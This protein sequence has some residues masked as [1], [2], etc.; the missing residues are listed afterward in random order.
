[1]AVNTND[2]IRLTACLGWPKPFHESK[3]VLCEISEYFCQRK[4]TFAILK[5]IAPV[6]LF[7]CM[8]SQLQRQQKFKFLRTSL[9]SS[10]LLFTVLQV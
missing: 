3:T 5:Q 4:G 8:N 9:C 6:S 7:E 1:M 2:K 10:A